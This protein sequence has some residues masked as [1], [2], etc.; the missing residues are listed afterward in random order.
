MV[1]K[2]SKSRT[3]IEDS[4]YD[5][6]NDNSLGLSHY[7]IYKD[8]GI[9][10]AVENLATS[11]EAAKSKISAPLKKLDKAYEEFSNGPYGPNLLPDGSPEKEAWI[12]NDP[13]NYLGYALGIGAALDD[14]D[15]KMIY[16]Y[17]FDND[18]RWSKDD[19]TKAFNF[20]DEDELNKAVETANKLVKE[21]KPDMTPEEA[22]EVA[23]KYLG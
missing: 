5:L 14:P 21:I 1:I 2:K 7:N 6:F 23:K 8:Q 19:Y 4:I 11:I 17:A 10:S 22:E 18:G 20:Y 15:S 12:S 3:R 13:D 9:V 16:V